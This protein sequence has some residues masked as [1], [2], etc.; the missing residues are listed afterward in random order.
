[1][2]RDYFARPYQ[3][4]GRDSY[5]Y[6]HTGPMEKAEPRVW[7]SAIWAGLALGVALFGMAAL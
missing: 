7:S 2:N 4:N 6:G 1:M 5:S 3:G